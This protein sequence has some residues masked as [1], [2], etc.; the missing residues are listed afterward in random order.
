MN[1]CATKPGRFLLLL[2]AIFIVRGIAL[3]GL[4]PPLEGFDEYQHIACIQYLVENRTLPV[5]G[6]SQVPISLYDDIVANPH[7]D[8]SYQQTAR[9]GA[10]SYKQFYNGSPML[11][12]LAPI[13]LYQAQH[14]PLYY[15]AMAPL[16]AFSRAVLGFRAT[17]YL[18]RCVNICAAALALVL[19]LYP[20]RRMCADSSLSRLICLAAASSPLFMVYVARVA[21]DA[22]ALMFAGFSLVLVLR[23]SDERRPLLSAGLAGVCAGMAVLSKLN[24]LV[25]L[26]AAL[27]YWVILAV[28]ANIAWR[29]CVQ[30]AVFFTAGYLLISLPCHVWAQ[31]QYAT[32]FPQQET[33]RNIAAGRTSIEW[34]RE[35]RPG[36]LWT[37]FVRHVVSQTLWTSGWSFLALPRLPAL[38]YRLLLVA[39]A[40]GALFWLRGRRR[41]AYGGLIRDLRP[42]LLCLLLTLG[43]LCA[44][45]M[46]ALHS[47]AA[48]GLINTPPH[49]VMIAYPAF[50]GCLFAAALGFGRRIAAGTA[51][52][53]IALFTFAELYGLLCVAVPYWAQTPDFSLMMSR[54]AS[55]HPVFPAPIHFFILYPVAFVLLIAALRP[56]LRMFRLQDRQLPEQHAGPPVC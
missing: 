45:Y 36:H 29:R 55:V 50:L 25:V 40:C 46:H 21:N 5:Y 31:V 6:R 4:Y 39:A 52:V 37:F 1:S 38:A 42:L 56:S 16:Y 13:D 18:L 28:V 32:F 43:T 26:P 22:F 17:V 8:F 10:L 33:L 54:L 19:L 35:I 3:Q 24:A 44:A 49:Y 47:L 53:M 7:P 27:C 11:P 2:A 23:A 15:A 12:G 34:L 41:T 20:I 48:Y 30:C 9:I 14:P 51:I